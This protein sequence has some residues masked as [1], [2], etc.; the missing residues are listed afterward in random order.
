MPESDLLPQSIRL[1]PS[2]IYFSQDS[3]S[4]LVH[5]SPHGGGKIPILKALEGILRGVIDVERIVTFDVVRVEGKFFALSGNRRL[6]IYRTLQKVGFLS[7]VKVT[8]YPLELFHMDWLSM[9]FTTTSEGETVQ[10][11]V[12]D[13]HYFLRRQEAVLRRYGYGPSTASDSGDEDDITLDLDEEHLSRQRTKIR[14]KK[15]IKKSRPNLRAHHA[16]ECSRLRHARRTKLYKAELEKRYDAKK[17]MK[18]ADREAKRRLFNDLAMAEAES[19]GRSSNQSINR[20]DTPRQGG[21]T[22]RERTMSRIA[23]KTQRMINCDERVKEP[24]KKLAETCRLEEEVILCIRY[25][26]V[27]E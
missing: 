8:L 3:I 14:N 9:K 1:A 13:S 19:V 20:Q 5:V 22:K 12:R 6:Y 10:V 23:L 16:E 17:M 7:S 11:R 18:T 15:K 24:Q 4:S 27:A 25:L 21:P 26:F 2:E